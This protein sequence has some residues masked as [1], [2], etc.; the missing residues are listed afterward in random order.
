MTTFSMACKIEQK[1]PF[2]LPQ[3]QKNSQSQTNQL[4]DKH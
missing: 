1:T 2:S 3:N 4:Y